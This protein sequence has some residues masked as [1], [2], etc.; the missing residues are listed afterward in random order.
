MLLKLRREKHG[1][2]MSENFRRYMFYAAGE[3][4]L[5][6]VGILIALQIDNW[7]SN[8][9]DEAA[10]NSY[11]HSI[12]GNVRND[13]DEIQR[14]RELRVRASLLFLQSNLLSWM[15]QYPIEAV[16]LYDRINQ[17]M[18]TKV[19]FIPNRSS[20]DALKSSGVLVRL[21]GRDAEKL[22]FRYYDVVDRIERLERDLHTAQSTLETQ[23]AREFPEDV[24]TF[25]L[26]DP[27]ALAPGRFKELQ[28]FYR[29]VFQSSARSQSLVVVGNSFPPIVH[30]YDKLIE[31]G[32]SF[33]TMIEDGV[34]DFTPA[35][36][37]TLE[38]LDDIERGVGNPNVI[39]NGRISFG[40]YF[41]GL[42]SESR[43]LEPSSPNGFGF[44]YLSA[45]LVDDALHLTYLGDEPWA[46]FWFAPR[47]LSQV[48]G[49][50]ASDFSRY[51]QLVLE[52][53]GES[54]G[55]L[56]HVNLK[57]RDDP[58]DGSQTNVEITLTDEWETYRF[59]LSVFDN[60]DL[61]KLNVL[62]FLILQEKPVS[63][64][65]RTARFETASTSD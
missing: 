61:E 22:L 2:F 1:Y 16:Y 41:M 13:L 33:V 38:K 58:D 8:R 42:V 65:I 37:Q 30:E 35:I 63:F 64:A 3:I 12:A 53:K 47:T 32:E 59:D 48:Y 26:S 36:E 5:V 11:L 25:A 27:A 54:G 9:Q 19:D 24:E 6:I 23:A 34:H 46:A 43:I 56:L 49:R 29:D 28:P 45:R 44:D 50:P 10:L 60:A 39:V 31:L 18:R 14:L 40:S 17:L 55:E 7:N 57:D 52:M 62:S 51:D 20:F 21:Q 15:P 4:V